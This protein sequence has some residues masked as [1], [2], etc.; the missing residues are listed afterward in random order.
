MGT[1]T[2]RSC[3]RMTR[4]ESARAGRRPPVSGPRVYHP[5]SAVAEGQGM[6]VSR[7]LVSDS[8]RIARHLGEALEEL[9]KLAGLASQ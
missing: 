6:N 5:V 8:W 7:E 3:L 9:A 2:L 4:A 1:V